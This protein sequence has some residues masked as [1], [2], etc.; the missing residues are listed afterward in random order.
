[1]PRFIPILLP[2]IRAGTLDPTALITHRLPLSDGS[3]AYQLFAAR[4]DGC[5]KIALTP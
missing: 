4:Q 1:V 3:R 5:V 2:L